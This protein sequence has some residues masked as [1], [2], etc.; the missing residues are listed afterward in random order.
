MEKIGDNIRKIEL[1]G[2]VFTPASPVEIKDLFSGRQEQISNGISILLQKGMNG[3]LYGDRGVGKTSI[4]NILKILVHNPSK[5]IV[6]KESCVSD[7]TFDSL[8]N[9]ILSKITIEYN[10]A[11]R[12]I[13]FTQE[14]QNSTKQI[15]ASE[16]IK[17]TPIKIESLIEIFG[18]LGKQL[19]IIIDEFDRLPKAFNKTLF[20]DFIKYVSDSFQS[21]K[22]LIVGVSEDVSDLIGEHESIVRNLK[23]IHLQPMSPK[24]LEGILNIGLKALKM[25]MS[26]DVKKSIIEFS[27]GYP[28]YTHSLGY[29]SCLLAITTGSDHIG[30]K[31][32]DDSIQLAIDNAHESIRNDYQNATLATKENIYK[33]VLCAS[34]FVETDEY[35]YFRAKDLEEPLSKLVKKDLKVNNFAFHLGK[36]CSSERGNILIAKGT[37]NRRRYKFKNPL[38]K[39]FIRL[40]IYKDSLLTV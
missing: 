8:W 18:V 7:D 3:I 31:Q 33:E 32:F 23:Q 21:V 20:S 36:F 29:Y 40:N 11:K 38:M 26:D 9:K 2:Q 17:S 19:I 4:A 5:N 28:H 24:E 27:S 25:T 39:A 35:G 10:S 16:L 22:I 12:I 14:P 6:I 30:R 13:G 34:S 1:L 15:K 37:K